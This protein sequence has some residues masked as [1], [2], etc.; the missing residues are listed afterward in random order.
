MWFSNRKQ[1][2]GFLPRNYYAKCT[3]EVGKFSTQS[4]RIGLTQV[5]KLN[6]KYPAPAPGISAEG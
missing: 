6:L 5:L 4:K 2:L 3:E 1:T